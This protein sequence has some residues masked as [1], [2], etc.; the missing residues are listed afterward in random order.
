M[1]SNTGALAFLDRFGMTK[2][3]TTLKPEAATLMVT[4]RAVTLKVKDLGIRGVTLTLTGGTPTLEVSAVNYMVASPLHEVGSRKHMTATRHAPAGT[5]K[6]SA[7]AIKLT[8]RTF[9]VEVPAIKLTARTYKVEVLAG[10][11]TV[12]PLNL[13]APASKLTVGTWELVAPTFKV[14]AGTLNLIVATAKLTVGTLKLSAPA[15]KLIVGTW[16]PRGFTLTSKV[17]TT[18]YTP[19]ASILRA[20]DS[21]IRVRR[22]RID[23]AAWQAKATHGELDFAAMGIAMRAGS[24]GVAP[25]SMG[26]AEWDLR[27]QGMP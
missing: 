15:G 25:G 8:A 5:L 2:R 4:L 14:P 13:G 17:A 24:R 21:T 6:L 10:K 23:V 16:K 1:L 12:E 9:N 19:P 18:T 26:L 7:P 27:C 3:A 22:V 11:L 20:F